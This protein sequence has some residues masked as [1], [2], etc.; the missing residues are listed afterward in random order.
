MASARAGNVIGG[1]DWGRTVWSRTR[2]GRSHATFRSRS[3]IQLRCGRGSMSSTRRRL[4]D[5][6]PAFDRARPQRSGGLELR[7]VP[8]RRITGRGRSSGVVEPARDAVGRNRPLGTRRRRA[9]PEAGYTVA[10]FR[11]K[12]ANINS[13]WRPVGRR[14]P[15]CC[16]TGRSR[17]SLRPRGRAAPTAVLVALVAREQTTA[18]TLEAAAH[19]FEQV[20]GS[21]NVRLIGGRRGRGRTVAHQRLRRHVDHDFGLDSAIAAR[22]LPSDRARRRRQASTAAARRPTPLKNPSSIVGGSA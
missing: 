15:C 12:G 21:H 19:G 4:P 2:S 3:A 10:G 9:S 20:D 8:C 22:Q 16:C 11:G 17:P 13:G 14:I 6:R 18:S 5:P 1:G 7:S